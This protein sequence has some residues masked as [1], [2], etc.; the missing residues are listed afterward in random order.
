MKVRGNNARRVRAFTLVEILIAIGIFGMIMVA[1]YASWFAIMRGTRVGLTAAAEVQRTRVAIHA[2]E[3]SLG[4]AVMYADNPMYYSFFADTS[5]NFAYL[6]FVAR[7][8]QS[9]P[10]SGLFQG[11]PVRRVTFQVDKEK[12]LL[13]SQSALLDIS[14]KPYTIKLA[15]KARVFAA[16]FYNPRRNEWLPEWIATNQLPT[17]VRLAIDFGDPQQGN[18]SVTIRS[19]PLTAMAITRVGGA[20]TQANRP[21]QPGGPAVIP[22]NDVGDMPMWRP[23]IGQDWGANRGTVQQRNPIFGD[24]F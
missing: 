10:G 17:M 24:W 23:P 20:G 4:S 22:G 3:E 16:E 21:G 11:Q 9:F 19:V 18:Q 12:N 13:L 8:P 15:P 5:G 2:L 1:I 7:L 14:E 6:S